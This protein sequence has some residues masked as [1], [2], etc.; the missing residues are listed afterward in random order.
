MHVDRSFGVP[1][2]FRLH[3]YNYKYVFL[4]KIIK[5]LCF[6]TIIYV[7]LKPLRHVALNVINKT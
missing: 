1:G 5:I 4:A 7:M 2:P 3:N 6:F